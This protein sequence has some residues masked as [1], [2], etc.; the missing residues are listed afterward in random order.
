MA[1][2]RKARGKKAAKVAM[3]DV[4]CERLPLPWV[5]YPGHYGTMIAYSQ[6][7]DSE[8]FFC[9]CAMPSI[10]NYLALRKLSPVAANVDKRR[11]APLATH[12]F[13]EFAAIRSMKPRFDLDRDLSFKDGLCHRCNQAMPSLR[14]CVDMY[15]TAFVQ[16][17]GWY[18]NQAFLRVGI[19]R[20]HMIVLDD[21]C[22]PELLAK[23]GEFDSLR[24]E[25]QAG[26]PADPMERDRYF[27]QWRSS[28]RHAQAKRAITRFVEDEA[29]QEFGFRKVGEGW[30]SES[31]LAALVQ[32]IF[33]RAS[34]LR[35]HR[36]DWLGGLELDIFLPDLRLAFE[37][38]GQQHYK[39]VELWGGEEGLESLRARD[40]AK[41][42]LCR[43]LGVTLVTVSFR[44]PLTEEHVRSRVPESL[45]AG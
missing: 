15:G 20:E 40:R 21:A 34:V 8:P 14:Y 12:Y 13:P 3:G 24:K 9:A 1:A 31:I 30:I 4:V 16:A 27:M 7:L 33:S 37:Y 29:R 41:A 36:P 11:M 28:R 5:H 23:V 10:S 18:V 42:R 26:A 17:Y 6:Y 38:Q 44:E 19:L 43:K 45:L 35:H 22:P 25:M 2:V 32:Q 39:A